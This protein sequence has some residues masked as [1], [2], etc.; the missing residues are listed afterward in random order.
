MNLYG[1]SSAAAH[2]HV[3]DLRRAACDDRL[4][5]SAQCCRQS[6]LVR[7]ARRVSDLARRDTRA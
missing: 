3:R 6:G 7:A 4:A 1:L 2:E 5:A